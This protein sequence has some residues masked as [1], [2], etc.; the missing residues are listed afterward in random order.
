ME[1]IADTI[2]GHLEAKHAALQRERGDR[3]IKGLALFSEGKDSLR[4][5]WLDTHSRKVRGEGARRRRNSIDD[6][7]TRNDRADEELGMTYGPDHEPHGRTPVSTG[8]ESIQPA[9][10][11][12]KPTLKSGHLAQDK[13]EGFDLGREVNTAFAR[14]SNLMR[15]AMSAEGVAFIDADF[16]RTKEATKNQDSSTTDHE[17]DT[18]TGSS[19]PETSSQKDR[20]PISPKPNVLCLVSLRR[21]SRQFVASMPLR[22]TL[23]YQRLSSAVLF[24]ATLWA[25]FSI[26]T[27]AKLCQ[28]RLAL[29]Y[30]LRRSVKALRTAGHANVAVA[31]SSTP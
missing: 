20:T 17:T 1:D 9:S 3:L 29:I 13:H 12:P 28:A 21:S 22:D 11:V 4:D 26:S 25:K 6:E 7:K 8:M 5:W 15:E 19:G 2:M 27:T 31:N 14:S 30:P 18:A 10:S 23:V 16:H 24:A